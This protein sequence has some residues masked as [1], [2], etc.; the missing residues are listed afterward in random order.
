MCELRDCGNSCCDEE[1]G[2]EREGEALRLLLSLWT[3]LRVRAAV[4]AAGAGRKA[5]GCEKLARFPPT[6]PAAAAAGSAFW[7]SHTLESLGVGEKGT[8]AGTTSSST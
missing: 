5:K 6:A 8:A 7:D 1:R 3:G 4:R 2:R